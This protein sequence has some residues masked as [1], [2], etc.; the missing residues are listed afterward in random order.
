MLRIQLT[1]FAFDEPQLTL[2]HCG[3]V[4]VNDLVI[5]VADGVL[6]KEVAKTRP[7]TNQARWASLRLRGGLVQTETWDCNRGKNTNLRF[8]MIITTPTNWFQ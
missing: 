2:W 5:V 1:D 4:C 8:S 6:E 7:A 3:R